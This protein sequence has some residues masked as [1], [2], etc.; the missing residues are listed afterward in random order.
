M[1]KLE[2]F[3]DILDTLSPAWETWGAPSDFT[4]SNGQL[5]IK[6]LTGYPSLVSAAT[7]DLT[8]SYGF[9]ELV[10][11]PGASANGSTE[12]TLSIGPDS[13]NCYMWQITDN[14]LRAYAGS[15][16]GGVNSS[17]GSLLY[18]PGV[19][20]YF[21]IR[22]SG[23]TIFWDTSPDGSTWTN[24]FSRA[25]HSFALTA[26]TLS[27]VAGDW[28]SDR[29]EPT[30]W[31][32]VNGAAAVAHPKVATFTE[33][34]TTLDSTTTWQINASN[35]ASFTVAGGVLHTP[36]LAEYPVMVSRAVYDLTDSSAFVQLVSHPI[37]E[38]SAEGFYSL[39]TPDGLNRYTWQIA[40]TTIRAMWAENTTAL[41]AVGAG[42]TYDAAAHKFLGIRHAGSTV[43]WDTSA[44]GVTWT[45]RFSM[46]LRAFP[47]AGLAVALGSGSWDG[48]SASVF[49]WDNLNTV[50]AADPQISGSASQT[51]T[52]ASAA[53]GGV[54]V[55]GAAAQ[56]LDLAQTAI[57]RARVT[58]TAAQILPLASGAQGRV[59]VVGSGSVSVSV[60][61]TAQGG[62]R[63]VGA[64]D[65][66][67]SLTG[68]GS[69]T[70]PVSGSATQTVTVTQEA[71]GDL[72]D[73]PILE[74]WADQTVTL[75]QTAVGG[76]VAS[77]AAGQ[78]LTI[79]SAAGGYV[80]EPDVVTGYAHQA[81]DLISTAQGTVTVSGF[82]FD[83]IFMDSF[84]EG[85][86]PV[87]G[88]ASQIVVVTQTATGE[89]PPPFS[90][91][92]DQT[93]EL[94]ST[95]TGTVGVTAVGA[96]EVVVAQTA[97]AVGF[98]RARA[99]QTLALTQT[100]TGHVPVRGAGSQIIDLISRASG[101]TLLR[102]IE[103]RL[104]GRSSRASLTGRSSR[105]TLIG[106]RP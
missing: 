80:A 66:T 87:E 62:V 10:S 46:T 85:V 78:T 76:A 84:A 18:D 8:E 39:T 97:R 61:Q 79:E 7:Y 13:S 38:V 83:L 26:V 51:L 90:G 91:W 100:A 19:H 64:A 48:D 65:Q 21:R 81:L 32:N 52:I 27:L 94:T 45:N 47:I 77:G 44:D 63:I 35:P 58:G 25:A 102:E 60:A 43:Y 99:V 103:P 40:G 69:G 6:A 37:S 36:C 82:G 14:P 4:V 72:K 86:V 57:A 24:H 89:G 33:V 71:G 70:V 15:R 16:N 73:F 98:V 74:A 67:L 75:E 29:T 41:T 92:A 5:Q 95:A 9:V 23:S 20:S 53:T 50:P 54:R 101:G 3:V 55:A 17:V 59:R 11:H 2:A 42:L 49:Q 22:H 31:D 68:S 105:K 30:V 34:F 56:T 93:V 104:F 106:E 28:A 96:V 88:T 12:A 1:A